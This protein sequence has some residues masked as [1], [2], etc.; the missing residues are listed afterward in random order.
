LASE[1]LGGGNGPPV[2]ETDVLVVGGGPVGSAL[3]AEL[4]LRGVSCAIVEKESEITYWVRAQ[5]VDMRTMEHLRRFGCADD[6]RACSA[7]PPEWQHDLVFCTALFGRELGLFRGYGFREED[8]WPVAA[9]RGQPIPQQYTNGVIRRRA[10]ELGTRVAT[11]WGLVGLEQTNDQVVAEIEDADGERRTVRSSYVVGCD[12]GRSVVREAVSIPRSGPGGLGKN[13]HITF[14]S[15]TLLSTSPLSPGA[16]YLVFNPKAGGVV[17][18]ISLNEF[19]I[20][21]GGFAADEDTSGVDFSAIATTLLGLDG[22]VEVRR[23]A[24]YYIHELVADTYR[25]GRAFLA[26]DAAHLHA[27]FGGFNMNTGIGDAV[28]LG[29]KLAAVLQGWGGPRLLDS[30]TAERRPIAVQ[31]SVEATTHVRRFNAALGEVFGAGHVPLED[32]ADAEARRHALGEELFRRTF[33]QWNTMGTVLDQRYGD[34]PVIVDDGTTAPEWQ[35]EVYAPCAKPG[36]RAPL[37]R[38]PDGTPL[39]DRLGK[40][41]TL[42]SLGASDADLRVLEATADARGLPLSVLR[43]DGPDVRELYEAALVL[44]RPDQHVAWRGTAP[45]DDPT[46]LIDTVRGA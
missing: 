13:M 6:L 43:L 22:E 3:A 32:G 14:R 12:G 37:V 4:R 26:G 44:I 1:V 24:P 33:W 29:W 20:H 5:N 21:L 19:A 15:K 42:L 25:S 9:E 16:F 34:S 11:G 38:N 30:Y 17:I 45:P 23:V 27:P 10:G 39:Y 36:H 31:R 18:P 35:P 2:A 41:F 7:V 28:D 46:A 8:S 40:G